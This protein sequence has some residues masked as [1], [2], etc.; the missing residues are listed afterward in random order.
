M[1]IVIGILGGIATLFF[2]VGFWLMSLGTVAK[3]LPVF[4]LLVLLAFLLS[5]I[6]AIVTH[7]KVDLGA[8]LMAASAGTWLV[9][10]VLVATW[11]ASDTNLNTSLVVFAAGAVFFSLPAMLMGF[12]VCLAFKS[13]RMP[14]QTPSST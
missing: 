14:A 12:A 13:L 3:S 7:Q 4:W 6:G 5:I 10:E 11:L 1:A 8:K 2:A 9:L